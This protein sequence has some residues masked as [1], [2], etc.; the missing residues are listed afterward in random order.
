MR[1]EKLRKSFYNYVSAHEKTLILRCLENDLLTEGMVQDLRDI[2]N[3]CG[4]AKL[5]TVYNIQRVI[6]EA[7][8]K[9]LSKSHTLR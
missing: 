9:Y 1:D 4:V 3:D 7:A 8:K 2:F 5:A 6:L